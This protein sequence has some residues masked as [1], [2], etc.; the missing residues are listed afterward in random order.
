M[1]SAAAVLIPRLLSNLNDLDDFVRI[2]SIDALR[3][4]V[5]LPELVP[6]IFN[7]LKGSYYNAKMGSIDA[8]RELVAILWPLLHDTDDRVAQTAGIFLC[9]IVPKT[10][11]DANLDFAFVFQWPNSDKTDKIAAIR[12][13]DEFGSPAKGSVAPLLTALK[14][15]DPDVRRKAGIALKKIAPAEAVKV[16]VQ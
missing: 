13:L 10:A 4:F 16:G 9:R 6:T 5:R 8:P 2:D 3:T 12:A 14:D 1:E 15:Q 11:I 7:C